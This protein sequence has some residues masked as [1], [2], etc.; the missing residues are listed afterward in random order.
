MKKI[1]KIHHFI[2]INMGNKPKIEFGKKEE[3]RPK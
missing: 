1:K 3:D 2:D